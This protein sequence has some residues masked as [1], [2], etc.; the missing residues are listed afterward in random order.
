MLYYVG[1]VYEQSRNE[2]LVAL[3]CFSV[4]CVT[5]LGEDQKQTKN[6]YKV[7][8][9]LTIKQNCAPFNYN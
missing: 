2:C 3:V 7:W 8:C 4:L 1:P 6:N 9:Q 5:A